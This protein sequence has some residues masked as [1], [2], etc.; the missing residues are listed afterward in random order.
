MSWYGKHPL[1]T[2]SE[3]RRLAPFGACRECI[4][5]LRLTDVASAVPPSNHGRCVRCGFWRWNAE[6]I[7]IEALGS[8]AKSAQS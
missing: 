8:P 1:L 3:V 5:W 2:K 7:I 6:R 4:Y